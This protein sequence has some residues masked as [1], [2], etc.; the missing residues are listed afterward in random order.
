LAAVG[1]VWPLPM[2]ESPSLSKPF[3]IES[4]TTQ[5]RKLY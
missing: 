3:A 1:V 5:S 4:S 2:W